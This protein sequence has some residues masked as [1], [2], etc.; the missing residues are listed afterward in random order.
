MPFREL[1]PKVMVV[2]EEPD[3]LND[4][5]LHSPNCNTK[6]SPVVPTEAEGPEKVPDVSVWALANCDTLTAKLLLVTVDTSAMLLSELVTLLLTCDVASPSAVLENSCPNDCRL[7]N[8][9][10]VF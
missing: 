1:V 10:M 3:A 7:V 9:V 2:A 6:L 8:W 4:P 5:L